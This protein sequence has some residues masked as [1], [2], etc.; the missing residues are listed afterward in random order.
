MAKC[1]KCGDLLVYDID[2]LICENE[3]CDFAT[4]ISERA[5]GPLANWARQIGRDVEQST[6]FIL[7]AAPDPPEENS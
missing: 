4:E 6:R 2:Y 3:F 5:L 7:Q 1:P